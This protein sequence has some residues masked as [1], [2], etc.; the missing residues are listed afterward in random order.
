MLDHSK[1]ECLG[2]ADEKVYT[3]EPFD[4]LAKN[5]EHLTSDGKVKKIII[6]NGY[7]DCPQDGHQV[8]V[9]YNAYI[10]Y[11]DTPFDST[12]IRKRPLN[13]QV[14]NGETILGLDIGVKSMKI[15]EKAQFLFHHDYAYGKMGCLE[16]IPPESTVLF[17]VELKKY[18]DIEAV[19]S[20]KFLSKEKQQ[21]FSEIYKY[22]KASCLTA[23][24]LVQKNVKAAIKE[25]NIIAGKLEYCTLN[26]DAE[27]EKQQTLLL[28]VYTNLVVCYIKVQSPKQACTSA[29][30]VYNLTRGTRLRT[31]AKVFFN[32][33][34]ALRMLG[35]FERAIEKLKIAKKCEPNDKLI[36]EECV[37][38]EEEYKRSKEQERNIAKA[39]FSKSES[40]AEKTQNKKT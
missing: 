16:R 13:F 2:L 18:I 39:I 24:D 35:E 26:D 31:P 30:K 21:E 6:R 29:N 8:T 28:R 1:L 25:Y 34:R 33:A 37:M 14:N 22:C 9:D 10:E 20:Y 19:S 7:G 27:Q 15:N 5:M 11:S 17:E 4:E 32:H 36:A 23:K 40:D 38:L 12:Y 3:E